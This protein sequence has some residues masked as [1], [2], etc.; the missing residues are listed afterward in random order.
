MK[1]KCRK[2]IF[3]L[4]SSSRVDLFVK[5]Q[6]CRNHSLIQI[7]TFFWEESTRANRLRYN[8]WFMSIFMAFRIFF[9][10]FVIWKSTRKALNLPSFI[11]LTVSNLQQIWTEGNVICVIGAKVKAKGVEEIAHGPIF[12]PCPNVNSCYVGCYLVLRSFATCSINW[13]NFGYERQCQVEA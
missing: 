9:S 12:A 11:T 5:K 8:D 1:N 13:E 3:L 6:N 2:F 4:F 10:A 7:P